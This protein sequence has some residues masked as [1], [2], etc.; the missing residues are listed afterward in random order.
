MAEVTLLCHNKYY[1]SLLP[2]KGN[3]AWLDWVM[4][5]NSNSEERTPLAT[6]YSMGKSYKSSFEI[7]FEMREIWTHL[8]CLY[9]KKIRKGVVWD[10]V[11]TSKEFPALWL[12]SWGLMVSTV[13]FWR[14]VCTYTHQHTDTHV[15]THFRRHTQC[16][17]P[18][19]K[20]ANSSPIV[21]WVVYSLSIPK[22]LRKAKD[23]TDLPTRRSQSWRGFSKS[24]N[25]SLPQWYLHAFG[26]LHGKWKANLSLAK[27]ECEKTMLFWQVIPF[28]ICL[29]KNLI[30]TVSVTFNY[31]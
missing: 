20:C 27:N 2:G 5:P 22:R 18:E 10:E 28:Y 4:H 30:C 7:Y 21:R 3:L 25:A 29:S 23:D 1:L 11:E 16:L 24:A 13:C 12:R 31:A 8:L 19:I 15:R 14:C 9:L 17:A 26:R 6:H